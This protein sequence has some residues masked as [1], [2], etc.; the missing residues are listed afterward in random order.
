MSKK[1]VK[2]QSVHYECSRNEHESAVSVSLLGRSFQAA[3]FLV[4]SLTLT[5]GSR[6][7][8]AAETSLDLA[9]WAKALPT[10]FAIAGVKT[11]PTYQVA[12]EIWRD[13]DRVV[14]RGG[15][16]QWMAR[17]VE[18]VTVDQDGVIAHDICPPGMRCDG[19]ARPAGF[20]STAALIAASKTGSLSG[21][22][23]VE[24]YGPW[25]VVCLPGETLGVARPI[26][27]PCFEIGS[28]AAIAEKN[29]D[30]QAFD[31]PVLE[32]SS[33]R[34]DLTGAAGLQPVPSAQRLPS[35][36]TRRDKAS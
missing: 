33:I 26:L 7:V 30:S 3:W 19:P 5:G 11:E 35:S 9:G 6:P 12:V 29:R 4:A 34:L 10:H 8:S 18:G 28:G 14:I 16:P 21:Q 13:G 22:V 17:S 23:P 1:H 36:P 25:R 31:G 32:P 24:A 27:D 20:L 15:A 2:R